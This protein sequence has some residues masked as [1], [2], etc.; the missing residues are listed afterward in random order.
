MKMTQLAEK[1]GVDVKT[2]LQLYH[3]R[4]KLISFEVMDKVCEALD[5]QPGDLFERIAELS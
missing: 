4:S 2:V 3:E 5:C 1:A